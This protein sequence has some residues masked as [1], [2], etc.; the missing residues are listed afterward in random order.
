M[1]TWPYVFKITLPHGCKVNGEGSMNMS[2]DGHGNNI[3]L[4]ISLCHHITFTLTPDYRCDD[5]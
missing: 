1:I 2:I 5:M 3:G 4:L